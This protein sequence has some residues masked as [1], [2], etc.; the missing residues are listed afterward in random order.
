L[1]LEDSWT[2]VLACNAIRQPGSR[3]G[4]IVFNNT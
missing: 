2:Q 1:K 4:L 3:P